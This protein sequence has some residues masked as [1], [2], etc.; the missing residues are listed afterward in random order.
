LIALGAALFFLVLP[1]LFALGELLL[2]VLLAVAGVLGR[3]LFRRPW[4]V[5]ALGPDGQ[6]H[7][8]RVVGWH[9]SGET[10]DEVAR[11]LEATGRPPTGF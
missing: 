1:A 7:E 9:A 3:V 2:I 4:T 10:R 8:W 6:H 5:D 11:H